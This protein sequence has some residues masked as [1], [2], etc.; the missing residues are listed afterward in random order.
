MGCRAATVGAPTGAAV[1]AERI[2]SSGTSAAGSAP[3]FGFSLPGSWTFVGS[4]VGFDIVD[5]GADR[6]AAGALRDGRDPLRNATTATITSAA[7]VTTPARSFVFVLRRD[8]GPGELS[9]AIPERMSRVGRA[10]RVP[11]V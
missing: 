5:C 9:P 4:R 11:Q 3:S 6:S 7:P 10:R 1:V 2:G 8:D